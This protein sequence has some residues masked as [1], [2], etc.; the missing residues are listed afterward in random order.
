MPLPKSAWDRW[1]PT[2]LPPAV[3]AAGLAVGLL[4]SL[5]LAL[6]LSIPTATGRL[7]LTAVTVARTVVGLDDAAKAAP[8]G[9]QPQKESDD[10]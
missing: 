3:P 7:A 1:G 2:P 10:G 8:V 9:D 5:L 4:K 6:L